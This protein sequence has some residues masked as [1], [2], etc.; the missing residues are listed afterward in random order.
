MLP[1]QSKR[2]VM[3]EL[4]VDDIMKAFPKLSSSRHEQVKALVTC[5][6]KLCEH[7]YLLMKNKV[8]V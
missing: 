2:L 3:P 4:T 8:P 1:L 5:I 7:R 6:L